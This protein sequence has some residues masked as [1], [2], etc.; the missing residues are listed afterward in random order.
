MKKSNKSSIDINDNRK[1][2]HT[3]TRKVSNVVLF[4]K[5]NCDYFCEHVLAF[6]NLS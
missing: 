4:A 3:I 6:T 1:I 5:Y 2:P